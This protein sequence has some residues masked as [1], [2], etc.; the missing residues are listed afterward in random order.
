[1]DAMLDTV[2]YLWY[3]I[4]LHNYYTLLPHHHRLVGMEQRLL[5]ISSPQVQYKRVARPFALAEKWNFQRRRLLA[6]GWLVPRKN[7]KVQP[8]PDSQ[9]IKSTKQV[10]RNGRNHQLKKNAKQLKP[11]PLFWVS[12]ANHLYIVFFFLELV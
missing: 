1:M 4:Y 3:I 12:I 7:A 6:Q 5:M 2:H 10:A 11:W 8:V 9:F